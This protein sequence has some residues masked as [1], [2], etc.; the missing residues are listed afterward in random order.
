MLGLADNEPLWKNEKGKEVNNF[1]SGGR[2]PYGRSGHSRGHNH[3]G[4]NH[5]PHRLPHR[6]KR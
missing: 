5:G 1:P 2:T 6:S 4:R 3:H